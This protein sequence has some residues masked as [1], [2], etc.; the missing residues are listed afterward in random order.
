MCCLWRNGESA[1][2]RVGKSTDCDKIDSTI[3]MYGCSAHTTSSLAN[4][5]M[6]I[7]DD[8]VEENESGTS[9]NKQAG[10]T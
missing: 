10:R 3:A 1:C 8:V 6:A 4:E 2:F 9:H 5:E 7:N